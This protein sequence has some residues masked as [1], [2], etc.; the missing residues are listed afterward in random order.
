LS[1]TGFR[2]PTLEE[3]ADYL[4]ERFEAGGKAVLSVKP[5]CE[6]G[7]KWAYVTGDGRLG[8]FR[9][10]LPMK[11]IIPKNVNFSVSG[12]YYHELSMNNPA[13]Q[14]AVNVPVHIDILYVMAQKG[15][16]LQREHLYV[17]DYEFLVFCN[18]YKKILHILYADNS[19]DNI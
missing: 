3:Y 10:D 12:D 13:K 4:I 18:T 15:F 7:H 14:E 19:H 9:D 16:Y 5:F 2:T 1:P 8:G 17:T 6:S 11:L